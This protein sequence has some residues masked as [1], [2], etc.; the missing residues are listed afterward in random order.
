MAK[1]MTKSSVYFLTID[2][3]GSFLVFGLL[4]GLAIIEAKLYNKTLE[5]LMMSLFTDP[6]KT[7]MLIFVFMYRG[8]FFSKLFSFPLQISSMC[9]F[10]ICLSSYVMWYPLLS[11]CVHGCYS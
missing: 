1:H 9:L 11:I 2:Y 6:S 8:L 7:I 5:T 3:C 10:C 4:Q